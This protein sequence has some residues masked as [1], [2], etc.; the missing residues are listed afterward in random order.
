MKSSILTAL[1]LA[2]GIATGWMLKSTTIRR[3][4]SPPR[5]LETAGTSPGVPSLLAPVIE[6][7]SGRSG[8]TPGS[9][10]GAVETLEGFL[11]LFGSEHSIA[12]QSEAYQSLRDLTS[13]QLQSL[14]EA[15]AVE[16]EN[17]TTYH[18]P[19]VTLFERWSEVD[20]EALFEFASKMSNRTHKQE[21]LFM[22]LKAL[23]R[24]DISRAQ[25]LR[26]TIPEPGIREYALH[27]LLTPGAKADPVRTLAMLEK[28]A[29]LS[30][31]LYD[32]VFAAL[33]KQD[34]QKAVG[35]LE[36][37]PAGEAR[38]V[39]VT[40]LA[41]TWAE[42]DPDAALLWTQSIENR[43]ERR[44][45]LH[46]V[47]SRLSPEEG[48]RF[49]R[50]NT[51]VSHFDGALELVARRSMRDDPDKALAWMDTLPKQQRN[52]LLSL[53]FHEFI[54]NDP[55]QA[56][57]LLMQNP[58]RSMTDGAHNLAARIAREDVESAKAWV[59]ELPG[60]ELRTKALSGL[61]SEM[62]NHD[63]RAAAAYLDEQG[64]LTS[65]A[66]YVAAVVI[67]HWLRDD[68]DSVVS[69]VEQQ[70]D[71][72]VH[73]HLQ[74][75][76]L[77]SWAKDD[78]EGAIAYAQK[79]TDPDARQNALVQVMD[80]WVDQ[81]PKGARLQIDRLDGEI[82]A[83]VS[84]QF[85]GSLAYHDVDSAVDLLDQELSQAKDLAA[86]QQYAEA[87]Q[88]I[89]HQWAQYD[90]QGAADWATS[91]QD[92]KAQEQAVHRVANNWA[93]YDSRGTSEWIAGLPH[94]PAR[95]GAI[96]SLV[97]C[98]WNSDPE[99]AFAWANSLSD[100]GQRQSQLR[101]VLREWRKKDSA[102]TLN[103]L[104]SINLGEEAYHRLAKELGY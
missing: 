40:S 76:L 56:K 47:L 83:K 53:H 17:F 72:E 51:E 30:H 79:I 4:H 11:A 81:D 19:R 26:D 34:I 43:L 59:D 100:D 25:T 90:L 71:P 68:R 98:I 52:S 93:Q 91:L 20:P 104:Q 8:T 96:N 69:W 78:P 7:N 66:P 39:A 101:N 63:A 64:L 55:E 18:A 54:A 65:E 24:K 16:A 1:A 13:P 38:V 37:V 28:D 6:G 5:E 21:G 74:G 3:E 102:A 70:E 41:R 46:E 31:F 35:S 45:A 88:R 44:A 77:D 48:Q 87:A 22:A 75:R 60:G 103:A 84:S 92:P 89:A 99:G 80:Q 33:S 57:T 27:A 62:A 95:D 15:L 50:G 97:S 82:R 42:D 61:V 85:I 9:R 29:S 67:K 94:G 49:L 86:R 2:A 10:H 58:S 23:A 32:P 36:S 12:R 14:A 73:R